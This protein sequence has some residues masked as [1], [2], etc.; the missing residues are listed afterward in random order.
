MQVALP[1]VISSGSASL[2]YVMDR[3]FLSW[4]STDA[5][6][7]ALPASMLH[8]T[9]ISLAIGTVNYVNAFVAQYHGAGQPRRIGAIVWQGIYLSLLAGIALLGCIPLAEKMFEWFSHEPAIRRLETEFFSVLCLGGFPLLLQNTLACFF[10]GRGKTQVIM[11]INIACALINGVLDYLLIF[12]VAGFPR[13]GI[14]GAAT[15]T[16]VAW[17]AGALMYVVA[18]LANRQRSHYALG[19]AWRFD[20]KLFVRLLRF[21]LPN[22]VQLLVD[23]SSWTVFVQLIGALGTQSLAATS[24]AFNLNTLAF[25]PLL[26]VGTAVVTLTGQRIGERRPELAVRTTWLAFGISSGYIAIFSA[27]YWFAPRLI[28]LPYTLGDNR[29]DFVEI[30]QQVIQL[31]RFVAVYSLFDA[32]AIIF[33]SATRGA[34]DTRFALIFSLVASSLLL[35]LPTYLAARLGN[36]GLSIPWTAVTVFI[37]VLGVGF[38][39]RFQQGRWKS[40]RVIETS[41][42]ATPDAAVEAS[43]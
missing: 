17:I 16:V 1:L 43:A 6:A 14:A 33:S 25:I 12:G 11:G 15:A 13:W 10:S 41:P 8:W 27:I 24:L 9:L 36:R 3:V 4:Y 28:L 42:D 31:L 21:G 40:M 26:G 39:C 19:S 20:P 5:V 22:G 2:M 29:Q 23:L 32:M 35:V 37:M 7:A 34:G 18:L 38:L 30:E